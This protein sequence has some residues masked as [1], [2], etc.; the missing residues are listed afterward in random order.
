M[1]GVPDV[2]SDFE[3]WAHVAALLRQRSAAKKAELLG[4]LGLDEKIWSEVNEDWAR[5]LNEDIAAGRMGRPSRYAAICREDLERRQQEQEM[6]SDDFRRKLTPGA[7]PMPKSKQPDT[8]PGI[9]EAYA[10]T[11]RPND[12]AVSAGAPPPPSDF[13]R[14]LVPVEVELPRPVVGQVDTV[15]GAGGADLVAAAREANEAALWTVRRYAELVVELESRPDD[16]DETWAA[17]GISNP[18]ARPHVRAHWQR[19]MKSDSAL[20]EKFNEHLDELRDDTQAAAGIVIP[21]TEK[22]SD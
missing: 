20:Q 19:K 2:A 21:Q 10:T 13:R 6:S 9:E 7:P 22:P 12:G 15:A 4:E 11:Q 18:R 1:A 17:A 16:A 5:L 14:E 3:A 8:A